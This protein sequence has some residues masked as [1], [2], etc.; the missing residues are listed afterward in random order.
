[1]LSEKQRRIVQL[2]AAGMT[3]KEIAHE[4]GASLGDIKWHVSKL[5]RVAGVNNRA[6]LVALLSMKR[7]SRGVQKARPWGARRGK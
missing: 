1:M 4:L 5:L 3:N 7:R 2:I 6:A